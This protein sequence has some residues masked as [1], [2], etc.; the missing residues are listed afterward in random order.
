[1]VEQDSSGV[2]SRAGERDV[3]FDAIR[4]ISMVLVIM[5]HAPVK[6]FGSS[7]LLGNAFTT[8]ILL[9]NGFFFMLSGRFNLQKTFETKQD[10]S[11]YYRKKAVDILVPYVAISMLLSMWNMYLQPT[12]INLKTWLVYSARELMSTNSA[13]HLWFMYPLIG[14]LVSTPFL[15]KMFHAMQDW[16][17]RMMFVIVIIW[18][19]VGIYLTQ[20]LKYG[21]SF[22]YSGWVLGG[23]AFAYVA[24]YFCDRLFR[25]GHRKILYIAGAI[26]FVVTVYMTT[27]HSGNW[28]HPWDLSVAFILFYMACFVFLENHL[29]IRHEVFAKVF[30]FL[31]KY[32]F[33]VYLLHWNILHEITPYI[34]KTEIPW[35]RFLGDVVVT[36]LI[37]LAAA[38]VLQNVL[39]RP[40]QWVARKILRF[41]TA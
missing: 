41:G 5:V 8:I 36:F 9:C 10:Y 25:E 3:T 40:L 21:I 39:V 37:C 35:L 27:Y 23:W 11:R 30:R 2:V 16:E 6:P 38:F 17:I 7:A 26:G 13:I 22:S 1:M 12:E 18:N 32:S 15:A 29:K 31:A 24:G 4:A 33:L 14:F 20:D 28:R 19:V 34:V